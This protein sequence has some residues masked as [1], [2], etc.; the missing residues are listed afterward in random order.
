MRH[1]IGQ[2]RF[3]NCTH[4]AEPDCVLK[5]AVQSGE[6][7]QERLALLQKITNELES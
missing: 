6:I 1:L 4:R 2:C 3:N 5:Q 7:R